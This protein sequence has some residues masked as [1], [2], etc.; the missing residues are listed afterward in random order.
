MFACTKGLG[1]R[2]SLR[3]L[4]IFSI[5]SPSRFHIALVICLWQF[6][7]KGSATARG[8][9]H[10]KL[11]LYVGA[12]FEEKEGFDTEILLIEE[13][14]SLEAKELEALGF[15]NCPICVAKT[16]YS[17]TDD[18]NKLGAP[19]ATNKG[20][21]HCDGRCAGCM[22]RSCSIGAELRETTRDGRSRE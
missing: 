10:P 12:Q 22:D 2:E 17:F 1:L 4:F 5:K 3:E 16:Q 18:Q 21:A 20:S 11:A 14:G 19:S 8:V 9:L 7:A 15:G 6:Q 13:G